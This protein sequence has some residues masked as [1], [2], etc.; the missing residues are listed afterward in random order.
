MSGV[1]ASPASAGYRRDRPLAREGLLAAGLFLAGLLICGFT[2]RRGVDPF[3]EGVLLQAVERIASGQ[4]PYQDFRWGYG[5]LQPYLLYL[6]RLANG[7]SLIDWRIIRVLA[8][9]A[10]ALVAFQLVRSARGWRWGIAAWAIAVLSLSQ[11]IS[12]N[13]TIFALLS[14]LLA[15]LVASVASHSGRHTA[16]G[17]A[18]AGVL[19]GLACGWRIDFAVVATLATVVLFLLGP[20]RGGR[21]LAWISFCSAVATGLLVYLPFVVAAGPSK[22]WAQMIAEP[23]RD[24]AWW[25]LE[26]DPVSDRALPGGSPGAIA[27]YLNDLLGDGLPVLLIAGL[28]LA[29]LLGVACWRWASRDE[30]SVWGALFLLGLGGLAYLYS[31]ADSFHSQPLAVVLAALAGLIG[32]FWW[33]NRGRMGKLTALAAVAMLAIAG[34]VGLEALGNRLSALLAPPQ[35]VAVQ[36]P[37]ARGAESS[38]RDALALARTVRRLQEIVP[39]G[40]GIFVAPERSDLVR[41]T[42]PVLYVLAQRPNARDEDIAIEAKPDVQARTVASLESN[43]PKAIVR[44]SA[45]TGSRREPNLRGVSSGSRLLD[46]Y[47]DRHYRQVFSSGWYTILVPVSGKNDGLR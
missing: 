23:L 25:R 18:L 33:R 46:H 39:P 13:P 44:W 11:P 41:V 47:I 24:G 37:V 14:A 28:L 5:P 45:P 22:P 36:L 31:R 20:A 2:I 9:S 16:A 27:G 4:V 15:V 3:D 6:V 12:A 34:L 38:P 42:A 35:L 40:N 19:A 43:R 7:P 8:D 21:K 29:A 1:G 26:I 17:A 32:G 10:T 30:R